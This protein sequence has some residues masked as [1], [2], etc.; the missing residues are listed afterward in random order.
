M[1]ITALFPYESKLALYYRHLVSLQSAPEILT[2]SRGLLDTI[3]TLHESKD[4][5]IHKNV[6]R[7]GQFFDSV[8]LI[9]TVWTPGTKKLAEYLT[10]RSIPLRNNLNIMWMEHSLPECSHNCKFHTKIAHKLA[11]EIVFNIQYIFKCMKPDDSDCIIRGYIL[12]N[13]FRFRKASSS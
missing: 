5:C 12:H 7:V 3:Y 2:D 1:V 13:D 4:Y 8:D 9:Y 6:Q 11:W 10:K